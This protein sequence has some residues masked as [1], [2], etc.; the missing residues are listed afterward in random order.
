MVTKWRRSI[1]SKL[2]GTANDVEEFDELETM[3]IV[4][5]FKLKDIQRESIPQP[6]PQPKSWFDGILDFFK[7]LFG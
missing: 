5:S 4:Q 6:Q 7:S 2:I 1:I 3:E